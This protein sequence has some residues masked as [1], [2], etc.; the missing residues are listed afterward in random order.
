MFSIS[1]RVLRRQCV[2]KR[3]LSTARASEQ[4]SRLLSHVLTLSGASAAI[5]A[6]FL[7]PSESRHAPTQ[8]SAPL[9]P[10]H[11]TPVILVESTKTSADTKLLTLSVPPDLLPRDNPDAFTPMWS[12]FVKDDDIQVERPYTPLEGVD[13]NGHM[14]FWIKKYDNGEVGRWLHSKQ[15]GDSIEIRGPIKTWSKSLQRGDWDEIILIS[16]GT[17]IA[18]FHQ[19]LH[20]MFKTR[21]TPFHGR[22]TLLHGSRSLAD[23][24]PPTMM[25]FLTT[26]SQQH[27][28]KFE[29]KLFVSSVGDSSVTRSPHIESGLIGR[30]ALEDVLRLTHRTPWW[31]RIFWPCT[32]TSVAL[33]R[34]V[35]VMVCGPEQMVNA[36]AGPYGRNYSQGQV[37]GFLGELG[38]QSHQ[39]WKL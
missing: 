21:D 29:L 12:V 24:P 8:A 3:F 11:F 7:W 10:S 38:L 6:Y 26:L 4:K 28:D 36:I 30:S 14:K 31:K 17:G 37:G 13:E 20:S 23:I 18:P 33:E 19:L 9:S 34:K 32:A 25:N 27:P 22:L 15:V 5:A 16:G 2:H 39:V 1:H 35:L